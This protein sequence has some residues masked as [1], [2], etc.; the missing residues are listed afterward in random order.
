[1]LELYLPSLQFQVHDSWVKGHEMVLA[2]REGLPLLIVCADT[3]FHFIK[4]ESV[5]L[6]GSRGDQREPEKQ[7]DALALTPRCPTA[8]RPH[9]HLHI[10]HF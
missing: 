5:S 2:V 9:K 10:S 6:Q 3:G 7:P 1:M 8:T 4:G